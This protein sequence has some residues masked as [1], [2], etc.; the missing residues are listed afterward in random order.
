MWARDAMWNIRVLHVLRMKET[1]ENMFDMFL[2][3]FMQYIIF[4]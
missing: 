2:G 4:Y 3:D 1:E